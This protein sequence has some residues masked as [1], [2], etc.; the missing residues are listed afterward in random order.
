MVLAMHE[1]LPLYLFKIS[2]LSHNKVTNG[3]NLMKLII[4]F[5]DHNMNLHVKFCQNSLIKYEFLPLNCCKINKLSHNY[6]YYIPTNR[7]S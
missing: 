2:K 5:Y 4:H 7:T 6:K 1:L 3:Q